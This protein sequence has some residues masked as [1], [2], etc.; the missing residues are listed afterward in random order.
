[1]KCLL[2]GVHCD[3]LGSVGWVFTTGTQPHVQAFELKAAE[4][5][6]LLEKPDKVKLEIIDQRTVTVEKLSIIGEAPS[7][8]PMYRTVLVADLRWKW[9]RKLITGAYNLRRRTGQKTLL[10]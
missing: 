9:S 2:N 4:A 1:M 8:A 7:S 5:A 6:A 3:A 10:T